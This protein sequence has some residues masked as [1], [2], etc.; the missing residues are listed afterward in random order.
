MRRRARPSARTIRIA[1]TAPCVPVD[2]DGAPVPRSYPPDAGPV[3]GNG[4][5]TSVEGGSERST[6]SP[7]RPG[8]PARVDRPDG[9]PLSADSTAAG[10]RS[11]SCWRSSRS[12]STRRR[13]PTL[14]QP[15]RVAGGGVPRGPRGDPLSGRGDGRRSGQRILPGRPAGRHRVTAA[16]RGLLPFPPLPAIVLVPFVAVVGPRR[17]TTRRSSRSSAPIDVAICWWLLG[18]L[19]I[20]PGRALA[21]AIFFAFG[22]VFWY[23][24]QLATTWYQAHI[25]AVG[26]A[27]LAVGLALGADPAA[28]DDEPA[29]MASRTGRG[30]RRRASRRRPPARRLASPGRRSP[31]TAPVRDRVAVRPGRHGPADGHLRRRRSS[32][33]SGPAA[34]GGGEAGR[35]ASGRPS[36]SRLLLAYNVAATGHVFHP[37]Y[38]HLYRLEARAYT[39]LGYHPEWARRGSPLPRPEPGHHVPLDAGD[40]ARRDCATRSARST[41]PVHGPGAQRGLFDPDCPLAMPRDIGMSILLTSPA[42]LLMIPRLLRRY[43]RSRLVTGAALA[44]LPIVLDRPD[45]LQPGLGPVRVSVQ[46]RRRAVRSATRGLGSIAWPTG[47][48]AG[49]CRWPWPGRG[50]GRRQRLGRG[51]GA[52]AR[53]VTARRQSQASVIGW[54]WASTPLWYAQHNEGRRPDLAVID[55]RTRLDLGPGDVTT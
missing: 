46:Q 18:R 9:W 3:T 12:S 24:A 40:P 22:T 53:V 8:R 26:L 4:S 41:S 48:G 34:A 39:A 27:M 45:A 14:L 31:S 44:V 5:C 42:Y 54:W 17:P 25:V 28:Q 35:P 20:G 43:G 38:E 15:L 6:G 47:P 50:V 37:A 29:R 10:S 21:T 30:R 23:A 55:E 13:R 7:G 33:S 32:C 52:P 16:A 36:R 19:R 11:A 2:R 49:R 1:P 51:L